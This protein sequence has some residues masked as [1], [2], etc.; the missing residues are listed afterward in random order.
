MLILHGSWVPDNASE[1]RGGSFVIWAEWTYNY[2]E[3]EKGLFGKTIKRRRRHPFVAAQPVILAS[4]PFFLQ[5]S[6]LIDLLAAYKSLEDSRWIW[7]PTDQYGPLGSPWLYSK[8]QNTDLLEDSDFAP[9]SSRKGESWVQNKNDD[10]V[11]SE[12]GLMPQQ[13]GWQEEMPLRNPAEAKLKPWRVPVVELTAWG[14]MQFLLDVSAEHRIQII[15]ETV[16]ELVNNKS[17]LSLEQRNV[18]W[19][20]FLR[21]QRNIAP[22]A[23]S[24][25]MGK[26]RR[27]K[28]LEWLGLE[29]IEDGFY[30]LDDVMLA[31]DLLY[32]Q[33]LALLVKEMII[34][35]EYLPGLTVS[36]PAEDNNLLFNSGQVDSS[37]M[38][39]MQR[40]EL[41]QFLLEITAAMPLLSRAIDPRRE[42]ND[43]RVPRKA[44]ALNAG[45]LVNQFITALIDAGVRQLSPPPLSRVQANHSPDRQWINALLNEKNT[46]LSSINSNHLRRFAELQ[47][48]AEWC[49]QSSQ[50]KLQLG[51][52]L[53]NAIEPSAEFPWQLAVFLQDE[54]DL[55]LLIPAELIWSEEG[56]KLNFAGS[57]RQQNIQEYLLAQLVSARHI[58]PP[59]GRCLLTAYPQAAPLSPEEAFEFIH[60]SAGLLQ[61]AGFRVMLPSFIRNLALKVKLKSPRARKNLKT[62]SF[63]TMGLATL[64]DFDWQL[65][66]GDYVLN[67]DEFMEL[68]ALKQ[69]LVNVRGQW[70]EIDAEEI[71]ALQELWKRQQ[72]TG[73]ISLMEVLR[74]GIPLP[75]SKN[76]LEMGN[77]K[78]SIFGI[79]VGSLA[80]DGWI[81]ESLMRL[82]DN[83]RL[84]I[85]PVPQG[86]HGKLRSYQQRGYSWLR[87]IT[88]QGLGA[89]L[90]DDMG[91]GKTIQCLAFLLSRYE[92]NLDEG[93]VLLLCPT[94]VV[95]NWRREA[96]RFAP[97]LKCLVHHG[98]ARLSGDDFEQAVSASHLI[99]SSYS[100]LS[101]DYELMQTVAW[102]GIILDEA[103]NIKN[104]DTQQARAVKNL[105]VDGFR[106]AMTGTPVENRL[107]ELWSIM[108]FLNPGYLGTQSGFNKTFA[109]P[110]ERDHD[111]IASRRLTRAVTPFILRR[112]KSD[113]GVV[114]DLPDKLESK[115]YCN[116]LKEQASL[117]EAVVQETMSRL[118][119]T[120]GMERRGLVLSTL[121]KLKQCCNH[122][123]LLLKDHSSLQGRSGKLSRLEEMLEEII[124]QGEKALIFTQYAQWA[125]LLQE[126]LQKHLGQEVLCLHGGTPR[127]AR[128][129]MV[130][131]FQ[132]E[133]SPAVFILSVKAGGVGINLT[134]ANHVFHYDRW[135]N[136]A[137]E[138]Q[139]SD[140]AYRIGQT[141]NVE[142]HKF[143]CA[144]TLEEKI[145]T[146]IEHK[147]ALGAE[148]VG[149]G[150]AQLTEL[151]SEE[152]CQ[153]L[154]LNWTEVDED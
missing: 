143:I 17:V 36:Y 145:D 11:I 32:W 49:L 13:H 65:S 16:K 132:E 96:N 45:L 94:S 140:R 1:Y 33:Q 127:L 133:K 76:S 25:L 58:Y 84:E 38:P 117:Y 46:P 131:R 110:I 74:S 124:A 102:R 128:E 64:L 71:S 119:E 89:C 154:S 134:R 98:V 141:R 152:L 137:V 77:D 80:A 82:Q 109:L 27:S 56:Q 37:W 79:P 116:L 62:N 54:E 90:A 60:E 72:K 19:K 121:L 69:P 78:T 8:L 135:W 146:L 10:E 114:P 150:E 51:L 47:S 151:S 85:L 91:L 99:I 144:G 52:R 100:L 136:P 95:G 139:A 68:V 122:P 147:R 53:E 57:H 40:K 130:Q 105:A 111:R 120:E 75:D 104:P 18:L 138:E 87:F 129:Q 2:E 70:V 93:P 67:K 4:W 44:A 7:L 107:Q 106:I 6:G 113:P 24:E 103:Q 22:A 28:D 61:M 112:Q 15:P 14:A 125:M 5:H 123:A 34:R 43:E 115:I 20:D 26:S 48:W 3:W 55:S 101:R 63:G 153:V 41:Q 23:S 148:V 83:S 42:T 35:Q 66:V 9:D 81:K 149:S 126:Y 59:L 12:D 86:F 118:G 88:D 142:I 31:D 50:S 21:R 108:D 73:Q 39:V 92:E 29:K 30:L 97:S